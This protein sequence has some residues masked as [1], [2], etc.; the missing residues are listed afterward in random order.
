MLFLKKETDMVMHKYLHSIILL[1][2]FLITRPFSVIRK[3]ND[4]YVVKINVQKIRHN[5]KK[6]KKQKVTIL[7]TLCVLLDSV[8]LVKS[9]Q[10]SYTNC[11]L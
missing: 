10:V 4:T 11:K 2:V 6:K 1:F 9:Y 5:K 7:N 3:D 8:I